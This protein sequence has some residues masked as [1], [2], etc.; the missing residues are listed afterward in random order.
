M[1]YVINLSWSDIKFSECFL[2]TV[3]MLVI[4]VTQGVMSGSPVAPVCALGVPPSMLT[5]VQRTLDR[6]SLSATVCQDIKVQIGTS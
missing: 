6:R 3:V 5:P 2:C 1:C 4:M